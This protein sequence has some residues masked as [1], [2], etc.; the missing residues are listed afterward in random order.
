MKMNTRSGVYT[1]NGEEYTFNFY[2][3]LD[4]YKKMLFVN[5]V[6][7]LLVGDNYNSVIRDL[8]FDYNVISIF[9]DV[10]ISKVTDENNAIQDTLSAMEELVYETNIVEIVKANAV[11]GIIDELNKAVDDNI[12]YR[13]GIHNNPIAESLSNL[14]NT[15]E[16]KVSDIDTDNM[17]KM[18]QAISGMSGELTV[19]KML[20]AYSKSDIFKE[21]YKDLA[22]SKKKSNVVAKKTRSNKKND[23]VKQEE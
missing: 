14:L 11:V 5:S 23:V 15:I 3:F 7:G 8:A 12:E 17:M 10:D 22:A 2:T 9:T 13:T 1:Y 21:K 20:E 16:S 18:A 19:D 4:S 6:T